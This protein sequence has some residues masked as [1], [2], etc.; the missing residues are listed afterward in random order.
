MLETKWLS[1]YYMEK[2]VGYRIKAILQDKLIALNKYVRE[3]KILEI[4]WAEYLTWKIKR[5]EEERGV[6]V[7]E[8]DTKLNKVE[9]RN[10]YVTQKL[11][12]IKTKRCREY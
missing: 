6:R 9:E 11:S 7:E 5:E 4:K 3:H 2:F 10:L 1:K 8:K 12:Y